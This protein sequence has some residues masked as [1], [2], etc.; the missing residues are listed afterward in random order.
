[1]SYN[2]PKKHFYFRCTGSVMSPRFLFL[3]SI[4]LGIFFTY[5]AFMNV[6]RVS[7]CV[8]RTFYGVRLERSLGSFRP[9]ENDVVLE[10]RSFA[11]ICN[12]TGWKAENCHN[13]SCTRVIVGG[14]IYAKPVAN[15][16]NSARIVNETLDTT[17]TPPPASQN[18]HVMA[19]RINLLDCHGINRLMREIN[20]SDFKTHKYE[21]D[22][23]I[24]VRVGK[25]P[26]HLNTSSMIEIKEAEAN[27]TGYKKLYEEF[28]KRETLGW[29]FI[30]LPTYFG[31]CTTKD[32]IRIVNEHV[33]GMSLCDDVS[34]DHSN[35]SRGS[36]YKLT[37]FGKTIV[38][39]GKTKAKTDLTGAT[40]KLV[41][42]FI[43]FVAELE[44]KKF[45]VEDFHGMN[46]IL[47]SDMSMMLKNID[48]LLYYGGR[49]LYG[50]SVCIRDRDCPY[51][52]GVHWYNGS[53]NHILYSSCNDVGEC[54]K[55]R[56]V[57]FNASMHLCAIS[58]WLIKF[59]LPYIS[60]S[61]ERAK[62]LHVSDML[63]NPYAE[64]RT[65]G[66]AAC[67]EVTNIWVSYQSV[68]KKSKNIKS[69]FHLA[70][71]ADMRKNY[72]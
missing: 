35:F 3:I 20:G 41:R 69:G 71:P 2:E 52:K 21:S 50:N 45:I 11:H 7:L 68:M 28:K 1:M 25:A 24:S 37:K 67:N 60:E 42:Y 66:K 61:K 32:R 48:N 63:S 58:N 54:N 36:C 4:T 64:V 72:I 27:T 62:M 30:G 17:T 39:S 14:E 33:F 51:P 43:C 38:K 16:T 59:Y 6:S 13:G 40:L 10:Y 5:E 26:S 31:V 57:G 22:E 56:C 29:N 18:V 46:F 34:K 44:E 23:T 19:K 8:E 15:A 49:N 55:G 12:K 65:S 53:A 47:K 70:L 9:F